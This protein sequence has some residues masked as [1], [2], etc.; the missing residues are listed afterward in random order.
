MAQKEILFR[1]ARSNIATTLTAR[2]GVLDRKKLRQFINHIGPPAP[3][4]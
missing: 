3:G 4:V 1:S 2:S